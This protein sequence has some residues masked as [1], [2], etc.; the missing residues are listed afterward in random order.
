ME[1]FT[2]ELGG[3]NPLILII[4]TASTQP[5]ETAKDYVTVFTKLNCKNLKIADIRNRGDAGNPQFLQYLAEAAGI[6][7][8]GGDQLRLTA[9][10]GGTEFLFNLKNRYIKD[11]IVIAGTSAGAAAMSTGMIYEGQKDNGMFK[12]DV[13]STTGL[14][15]INNVTID[16]HFIARGRIIRMAHRLATNPGCIGIGLE[17]DTGIIIKGREAEVIGSG[18]IV[19]MDARGCT[20][21]NI[22]DIDNGDPVT[23]RNLK[24]DMLGKGDTFSIPDYN[25]LHS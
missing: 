10:L 6:I 13:R 25:P 19:L 23:I 3:E 21:T 24:V 5:E 8:T 2:K 4:P 12:G 20:S 15:L 17:E 16:T 7:F 18:L 1:R 9:I 14:E 22:Y 11:P